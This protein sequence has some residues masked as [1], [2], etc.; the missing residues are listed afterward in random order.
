MYRINIKQK[1]KIIQQTKTEK[2]GEKRFGI[3]N[4][5]AQCNVFSCFI[6]KKNSAHAYSGHKNQNN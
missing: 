3:H 5:Q 2:K 1:K 4:K 6:W